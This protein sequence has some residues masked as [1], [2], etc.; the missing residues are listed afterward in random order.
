MGMNL[1]DLTTKKI[2]ELVETTDQQGYI[3]VDSAA[4]GT[5]KFDIRKLALQTSLNAVNADLSDAIARERTARSNLGTEVAALAGAVIPKGSKTVSQISSL[6][7][8][9]L[10]EGWMYTL[11]DSGTINYSLGETAKTLEV[12]K[13]DKI[14]WDE[15]DGWFVL[16]RV[17]DMSEYT[18]TEGFATV[19]FSGS[20]TDLLN[21]PD[22]SEYTKTEGF[23]S[24]AF[25]GQYSDLQN[26]PTIPTATSDLQ[27]DSGFLTG[28]D[29]TLATQSANGLM[30]ATDKTKLDNIFESLMGSCV[31]AIHLDATSGNDANDGS[32]ASTAVKTLT[33]A[34]ELAYVTKLPIMADAGGSYNLNGVGASTVLRKE[35]GITAGLTSENIIGEFTIVA[36]YS[37]ISI[38]FADANDSNKK[39]GFRALNATSPGGIHVMSLFDME[40]TNLLELDG[41]NSFYSKK[42][43]VNFTSNAREAILLGGTFEIQASTASAVYVETGNDVVNVNLIDINVKNGALTLGTSYLYGNKVYISTGDRLQLYNSADHTIKGHMELIVNAVWKIGPSTG[44]TPHTTFALG[45][46]G[47]LEIHCDASQS[48]NITIAGINAP[49]ARVLIDFYNGKS[50]TYFRSFGNITSRVLDVRGEVSWE[51][52]SNSEDIVYSASEAMYLNIADFSFNRNKNSKYNYVTIKSPKIFMNITGGLNLCNVNADV[53][54]CKVENSGNVVGQIAP[55][56]KTSANSGKLVKIEADK[57]TFGP[58]CLGIAPDPDD[59]TETATF[60]RVEID[61]AYIKVAYGN[62]VAHDIY[63]KSNRTGSS[64]NGFTRGLHLYGEYAIQGAYVNIDASSVI[65]E[66]NNQNAGVEVGL[67]CSKYLSRYNWSDVPSGVLTSL[68]VKAACLYVVDPVDS[69]TTPPQMT[70]V[71]K[72]KPG[73]V[74]QKSGQFAHFDIGF[75]NTAPNNGVTFSLAKFVHTG[76]VMFYGEVS[77]KVGSLSAMAVSGSGSSTF[78]EKNW[79]NDYD[80]LFDIDEVKSGDTGRVTL[81][82]EHIG[83]HDIY[84]STDNLPAFEYNDGISESTPVNTTTGLIRALKKNDSAAF[85]RIHVIRGSSGATGLDLAPFFD[86]SIASTPFYLEIM[87]DYALDIAISRPVS[88]NL[89]YMYIHDF[90]NVTFSGPASDENATSFGSSFGMGMYITNVMDSLAINGFTESGVARLSNFFVDVD[91]SVTISRMYGNYTYIRS[92]KGITYQNTDFGTSRSAKIILRGEESVDFFPLDEFN[93]VQN[94]GCVSIEAASARFCLKKSKLLDTELDMRASVWVDVDVPFLMQDAAISV[95]SLTDV[96]VWAPLLSNY[97]SSEQEN[98]TGSIRAIAREGIYL[99][100]YDN[101]NSSLSAAQKIAVIGNKISCFFETSGCIGLNSEYYGEFRFVDNGKYGRSY[102]KG[103]KLFGCTGDGYHNNAMTDYHEFKPIGKISF[104]GNY[105]LDFDRVEYTYIL[106]MPT[107]GSDYK[108]KV[109]LDISILEDG[110]AVVFDNTTSSGA[111]V[112]FFFN[113]GAVLTTGKWLYE[114]SGSSTFLPAT[115]GY[116]NDFTVSGIINYCKNDG[117]IV[118]APSSIPSN[119]VWNV[120][121][122]DRD[123]PVAGAG[124]SITESNSGRVFSSVPASA[125]VAATISSSDASVSIDN[126]KYTTITGLTSAVTSLTV[127]VPETSAGTLQEAAFEFTVP[128]GASMTTLTAKIGAATCPLIGWDATEAVAGSTV[129]GVIANGRCTVGIYAAS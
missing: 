73:A 7:T 89:T 125:S 50:G 95:E 93:S 3:P 123:K 74:G 27:N 37:G 129:V 21:A 77:G 128:T 107:S 10:T 79:H 47:N 51:Q 14:V 42:G 127:T 23:A 117:A 22:M 28:N 39:H 94:I 62:I 54:I 2:R 43:H 105:S 63:I 110:A 85:V 61:A 122:T 84:V 116:G 80:H 60:K 75:V 104:A 87:G 55:Y 32:S 114:A 81:H 109:S 83:T 57:L 126:N 6:D 30:S 24:V 9:D 101:Q 44:N 26:T 97:S 76:S 52:S 124:V 72:L 111:K 45:A 70:S 64:A 98:N 96:R 68:E 33:R 91:A 102:L 18:K 106:L 12:S 113:I 53:F 25:S 71:F 20:F 56:T 118:R 92:K 121:Y 4:L 41:S 108:T 100:H 69:S 1:T 36:P 34:L 16:G 19:A 78:K 29:L 82:F 119:G 58:P 46:S 115:G 66:S 99:V 38:S 88:A 103:T 15:E 49:Y 112:D 11:K 120:T 90:R 8:T 5:K 48:D 59:S 67:G 31:N 65:Y 86:P 40:I 13:N 35:A 17:P